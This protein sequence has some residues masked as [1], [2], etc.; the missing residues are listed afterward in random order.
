VKHLE[1]SLPLPYAFD[2][3]I[4]YWTGEPDWQLLREAL[5]AASGAEGDP[6]ETSLVTWIEALRAGEPAAPLQIRGV[7]ISVVGAELVLN[8]PSA[9]VDPLAAR[10]EP[11]LTG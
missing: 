1:R 7:L 2:S 6:A 11:H 3:A 9:A 8:G 10:L 5:V 4:G